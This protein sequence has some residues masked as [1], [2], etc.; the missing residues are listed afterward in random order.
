M[1][2]IV[3]QIEALQA[4]DDH[5]DPP[6]VTRL[7]DE[8]QQ[9]F[10]RM[11]KPKPAHRQSSDLKQTQSFTSILAEKVNLFRDSLPA[12]SSHPSAVIAA[13]KSGAACS[14]RRERLLDR[15]TE[16]DRQL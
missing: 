5:S 14:R 9:N 7:R 11:I 13:S 1:K 6:A 15:S 2:A 3:Y 12:L 4:R 16:L 8:G 10:S